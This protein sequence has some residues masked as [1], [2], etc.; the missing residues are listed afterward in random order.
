MPNLERKLTGCNGS[1]YSSCD[2]IIGSNT[3]APNQCELNVIWHII[4]GQS[5]AS[6]ELNVSLKNMRYFLEKSTVDMNSSVQ[7][8]FD[9]F[10]QLIEVRIDQGTYP[11][12]WTLNINKNFIFQENCALVLP[13]LS[14]FCEICENREQFR[15]I[16]NAMTKLH[17]SVHMENAVCHKVSVFLV[18]IQFHSMREIQQLSMFFTAYYLLPLQIVF[19]FDP[20]N[21]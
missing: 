6:H 16:K 2:N 14:K 19:N 15:W 8:I 3:F 7:V 21:E 13:E 18:S 4:E 11:L 1:K 5:F 9:V 20:I 17:E 12:L 10:T